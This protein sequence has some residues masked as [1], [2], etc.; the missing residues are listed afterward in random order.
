MIEYTLQV[1]G[2][3]NTIVPSVINYI[4]AIL[5]TYIIALFYTPEFPKK[6]INVATLLDKLNTILYSGSKWHEVA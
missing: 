1:F 5:F 4:S 3:N 6:F 2:Y